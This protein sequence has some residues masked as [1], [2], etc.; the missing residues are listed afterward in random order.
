MALD[1]ETGKEIWRQPLEGLRHTW[2]T[3]A[4][5]TKDLRTDLVLSLPYHLWGIDPITGEQ[6]WQCEGSQ[7]NA[8]YSSVIV[9][10]DVVY[11]TGGRAGGTVAVRAGGEGEVSQTLRLWES[12]RSGGSASPIYHGDRLYWINNDT[13]YSIDA[14]TGHM[15]YRTRLARGAP[16]KGP[17]NGGLTEASPVVSGDT[18]FQLKRN[19]EM[20]II[21]LGDQLNELPRSRFTGGGEFVGTPAISKGDMFV[22]STKH[23]YCVGKSG[24]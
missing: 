18:M 21:Q 11:V 20:I 4:L 7:D 6:R 24:D 10:E 19:G 16:I 2:G 9:H 13:A 14:K 22:R 15:V 17:L 23:L 3:P 1:K 12:G 8:A 5:V